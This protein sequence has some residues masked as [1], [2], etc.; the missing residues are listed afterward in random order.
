MTRRLTPV[1]LLLFIAV[2]IV[3]W[4]KT[5]SVSLCHNLRC[6]LMTNAGGYTP[7]EIYSDTKEV[8][9]AL[10]KNNNRYI[11]IEARVV[12]PSQKDAELQ[13][14]TSRMRALFEKA[15]A[16]YPGEISDA[17]VCDPAFIPVVKEYK[18]TNISLTYFTGYL[19]NRM[20]FGSCSL[21]QAVYK[22]IAAYTY[23]SADNLFVSLELFAPTKEFDA[24]SPA[25]EDQIRSLRCPK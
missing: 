9:R 10:Y 1:L 4:Q 13:A 12:D 16:P 8:Y 24:N 14:A 19:N 17:I 3:A 25:L 7:E 2:A 6:L 21:D 18:N 5:G 20:T 23:C 15:P 11:R 22:G